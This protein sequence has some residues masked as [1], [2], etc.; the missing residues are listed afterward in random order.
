MKPFKLEDRTYD[1]LEELKRELL[2][3]T[4]D[5]CL[6]MMFLNQPSATKNTVNQALTR[7][8]GR[9]S[10]FADNLYNSGET[11]EE[12]QFTKHLENLIIYL[13][14][15]KI[16]NKVDSETFKAKRKEITKKIVEEITPIVKG[17]ERKT[18][19]IRD[20]Y[21]EKFL[22]DYVERLLKR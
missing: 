13:Q 16:N 2:I 14:A 17:L 5:G 6:Y 19:T 8:A 18:G 22:L 3:E 21:D 12:A 20:S 11:N 9:L 15:N 4:I 1:T 10:L 7:Y